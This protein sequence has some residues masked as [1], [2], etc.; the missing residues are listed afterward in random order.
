MFTA[1][2]VPLVF[3]VGDRDP[4]ERIGKYSP[5]GDAGRFGVP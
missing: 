2:S 1:A 3:A 5:H 4:I